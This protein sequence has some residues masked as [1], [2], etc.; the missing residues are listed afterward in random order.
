MEC[1]PLLQHCG[2]WRLG[3]RARID[4][5]ID[6]CAA[7]PFAHR[8]RHTGNFVKVLSQ[9]LVI[10]LAGMTR[11][12]M[13]NDLFALSVEPQRSVSRTTLAIRA[14]IRWLLSAA[15]GHQIGE[16]PFCHLR[17]PTSSKEKPR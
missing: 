6:A 17:F 15:F 4:L 14:N 16:H 11:L 5:V 12:A 2:E 10:P 7:A 3:L 9:P 1:K 8:A 13:K